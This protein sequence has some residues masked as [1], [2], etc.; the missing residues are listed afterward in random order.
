MKFLRS[1]ITNDLTCDLDVKSTSQQFQDIIDIVSLN[2]RT[3]DCFRANSR[4]QVV[5]RS[6]FEILNS[7]KGKREAS[8]G[9]KIRWRPFS[10]I[11]R[12]CLVYNSFY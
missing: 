11:R 12:I 3:Y 7:Q 10:G 1:I 8:N 2:D 9:Y 6:P 4:G 5:P